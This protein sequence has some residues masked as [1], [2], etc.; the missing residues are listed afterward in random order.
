VEATKEKQNVNI[1]IRIG[2]HTGTAIGGI[3]GTVRFHF[4][5]WGRAMLGA[6]QGYTAWPS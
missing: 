2:I 4:D 6:R 1:G 5:M 3:I